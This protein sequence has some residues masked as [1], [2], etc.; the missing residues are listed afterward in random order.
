[1]PIWALYMKKVLADKYLGYSAS[2]QFDVPSSFNANSG[3]EAN[4]FQ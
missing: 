2:E 3:C 1:L 4:A